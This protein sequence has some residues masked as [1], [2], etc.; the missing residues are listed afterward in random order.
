MI[1]MRKVS[2]TILKLC[3]NTCGR[4]FPSFQYFGENDFETNGLASL[5][6]TELDEVVLGET[7]NIEWKNF[8]EEGGATFESRLSLRLRRSDLKLVRLLRVESR[9]YPHEVGVS[10]REFMENYKPA[11]LIFSC[12]FCDKGESLPLEKITC[13]KY[14]F[15]GGKITLVGCLELDDAL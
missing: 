15:D 7:T 4:T 1:P 13:R 14:K 2:G 12:I 6:S 3:C 8:S 9:D 5:T 11:K 10:F